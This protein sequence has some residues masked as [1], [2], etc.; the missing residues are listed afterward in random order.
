MTV[1]AIRSAAAAVCTAR[2]PAPS[3][4]DV[5]E[6]ERGAWFLGAIGVAI[7]L[8]SVSAAVI[9]DPG[10]ASV[11]GA[12]G[13]VAVIV[14]ALG[15]GWRTRSRVVG[16]VAAP[17]VV[18]VTGVYASISYGVT[19]TV[20]WLFAF[21]VP[22]VGLARGARAGAIAGLVA[23]PILHQVET[24][25]LFD[26]L[27]PQ[28]PFGILILVALGAVPGHLMSLARLRRVALDAELARAVELLDETERARS[29]ELEAKRQSVFM[30]ARAAEARDGT[31]GAHINS[32]RDLAVELAQATG[33]TP[34]VSELIG[35]SG[36]L[37]DVGKLRVP[38][39]ILLKPGKLDP[40]EWETMQKHTIWGE[41]LL[42]GGEHFALARRIA[43][44]HHENWDGSGYPD[45]VKGEEIPFEARLVRI[46][47]VYDALRSE[48]PY[49][50]AWSEEEILEELRRLRGVHFDPE[51]TD[52]FLAL[53]GA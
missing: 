8:L 6:S 52:L 10:R 11:I 34:A 47:D 45:R 38:D 32:V 26:P 28:G 16:W 29:A 24:G 43:R 5:L 42:E 36:M 39:S 49:K 44:W 41:E 48:R 9:S 23:A 46:V 51:L 7:V 1:T 4:V 15:L 25:V 31:T 33:A 37:H 30:L 13:L 27:D 35:W 40:H 18:L 12:S 19:P 22:A 14:T 17:A 50:P 20:V 3:A 21:L 2:S 53:R